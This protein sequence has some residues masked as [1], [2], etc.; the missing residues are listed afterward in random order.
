MRNRLGLRWILGSRRWR[1][2][3]IGGYVGIVAGC[4]FGGGG[5]G[6]VSRPMQRLAKESERQGS[7]DQR[8]LGREEVTNST[9]ASL[10]R[11]FIRAMRMY[12]V[13]SSGMRLEDMVKIWPDELTA[14]MC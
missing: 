7:N 8:D 13:R 4:G 1:A 10:P 2:G 14:V 12:I 5:E 11:A 9:N 3:W 6:R